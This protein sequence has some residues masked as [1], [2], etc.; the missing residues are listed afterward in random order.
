MNCPCH[1]RNRRET[2]NAANRTDQLIDWSFWE[3][4]YA[5]K[6]QKSSINS[7]K[8]PLKLS[9]RRYS[10]LLQFDFRQDPGSESVSLNKPYEESSSKEDCAM[11]PALCQTISEIT[12]VQFRL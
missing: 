11:V 5:N 10:V 2:R 6:N 3:V 9:Q 4:K 12:K 1:R 8:K 7:L